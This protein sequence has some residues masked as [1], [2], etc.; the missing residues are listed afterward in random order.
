MAEHGAKRHERSGAWRW[1]LILVPAV[2]VA[3][4]LSGQV[5]DGAGDPWF[6]GLA[7]PEIYPPSETFGIVWPILYLMM[8]V[9]LALVVAAWGV[10]GRAAAIA[11]FLVQLALNLAWP[12]LFFGAHRIAAG[13]W[14]LIALDIAVIATV[15]LFW[16]VRRA[17]GLLLLP[18][19][20]WVL[21]AT[22]LNA[23]FLRL[24]PEADGA[25]DTAMLD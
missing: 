14:L 4:W 24:N 25:G 11:A 3:G 12:P 7:K 16:R 22:L 21:F 13:L 19:L 9:A 20:G 6:D 15:V 18:Y 17:A 1:G 10:A 2:M 5:G 8:G 23:E